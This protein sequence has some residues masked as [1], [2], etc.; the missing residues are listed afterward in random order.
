MFH[1]FQWYILRVMRSILLIGVLLWSIFSVNGNTTDSVST[2]KIT[3]QWLP[4]KLISAFTAD[5][6]THRLQILK[7]TQGT[8]F[9]GSMGGQ[10]PVVNIN[11]LGKTLQV[12]A[13]GS[14]YLTLQRYVQRGQV[15]NVD[16]FVDFLFDLE[17]RKSWFLRGGFGHTSQ[18]IADDAVAS[19]ITPINYVKDYGQLFSVHKLYN[20]RIMLYEGL[21]YFD[22][23]K[24]GDAI[25]RDLSGK[26]LLQTGGEYQFFTWQKAH[27]LYIAGDIKFR[28]EFSFKTTQNIQLGYVANMPPNRRFRFAYNYLSGFDERGQFYNQRI[29]LHTLG[30]YFEW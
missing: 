17:L 25:P 9:F 19:G 16:F 30:A 18:H 3:T 1:S 22:N 15:I 24:I 28:Q 6:R 29:N 5:A 2:P 13:A 11:A 26:I 21:Y 7:R 10:F 14:T 8:E 20:N 12:S 4:N 27:A 23:F